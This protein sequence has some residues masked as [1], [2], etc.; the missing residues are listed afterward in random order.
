M[1]HCLEGRIE[2]DIPNFYIL[3]WQKG[4]DSSYDVLFI[5]VQDILSIPMSTIASKSSFSSGG[6]VLN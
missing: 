2:D 1:D 3:D 4:K 5:M 6:W